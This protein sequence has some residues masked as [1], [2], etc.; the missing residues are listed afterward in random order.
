MFAHV[1][2]LSLHRAGVDFGMI[3]KGEDN[4]SAVSTGLL[5][6]FVVFYGSNCVARYYQMYQLC[7]AMAGDVMCWVGLARVYFPSASSETLWNVCRHMVG[8]VYFLY[9]ELGGM[10]SDGG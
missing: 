3:V 6:F 8:S 9:F 5:V 2:F 10:A 1:A 4:I 7:M